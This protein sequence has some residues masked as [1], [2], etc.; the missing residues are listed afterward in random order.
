MDF[1]FK[2]ILLVLLSLLTSS[3][4][5]AE[6]IKWHMINVN[7]HSQGD[8][9]LLVDG[10]VNVLI[11]AGDKYAA[12]KALIPYLR[13]LSI[14]TID[15]FFI[16]HPH[17]DHYG[18][19]AS[20]LD[21]GIA[22]GNLYYNLPPEGMDD[23]NYKRSEF[24]SIVNRA[25]LSGAIAS[26]IRKGFLLRL[27]SSK[28]K[29]LYAQ[30][31]PELKSGRQ[32]SINDYSLILQWDAGNFRTL[33]AGDLDEPLGDELAKHKHFKADILKVPHHG[34]TNVA[35]NAFFD[36]VSPSLNMFPSTQT[37]WTHSRGARV[38]AWTLESG[39]YYCNNGL[40]GNVVL[41]IDGSKIIGSSEKPSASCPNGELNIVPG[42]KIN[43]V[44]ANKLVGTMNL[45]LNE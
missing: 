21:A 31:D 19:L 28:F 6:P 5:F 10:S 2:K 22:I 4:G 14:N 24:E 42:D 17:T 29:V 37:L 34:V 39:V 30:D 8:A 26:N 43:E 44:G 12:D 41:E 35:P 18:G 3:C 38:K 40:N 16:S 32:A 33:F 13:S 27:P 20:I 11:D 9:H 25:V 45:L 23:W 15:H 1:R 36:V 7:Y